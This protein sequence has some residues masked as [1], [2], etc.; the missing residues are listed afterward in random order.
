MFL[1]SATIFPIFFM[2]PLGMPLSCRAIRSAMAG[3][4]VLLVLTGATLV[5]YYKENNK[6]DWRG[7]ARLV[8]QLPGQ[9]RLIIFNANDGRL[10]FDYY[11]HYLP[12]DD[13][14][15]VP[16]DFYDMNPPR[17]MR[18]VLSDRDLQ[19]LRTRLARGK[20]DLIILVLAHQGWGDPLDLTRGL[21]EEHWEL[22]GHYEIR[23]LSVEWYQVD[24]GD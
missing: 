23:D 21:L 4:A 13:A 20:Y 12:N 14:T 18:R 10:P 15:G 9:R 17:T 2:L 19:P 8:S 5:G 11:Y 16:T 24:A 6:E 3:V 22:A 1:T 7:I